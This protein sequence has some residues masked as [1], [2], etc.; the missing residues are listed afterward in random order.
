MTHYDPLR[1]QA[2]RLIFVEDSFPE[3]LVFFKPRIRFKMP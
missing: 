1:L 3:M 2:P